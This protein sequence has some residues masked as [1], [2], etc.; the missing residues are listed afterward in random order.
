[1]AQINESEEDSSDELGLAEFYATYGKMDAMKPPGRLHTFP[2]TGTPVPKWLH[3][4]K[5][6]EVEVNTTSAAQQHPFLPDP[7]AEDEEKKPKLKIKIALE[8]Q[9]KNILRCSA[10]KEEAQLGIHFKSSIS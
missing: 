10:T 3:D 5:K 8:K 1:M 4:H 2:G 6:E 7:V 9:D